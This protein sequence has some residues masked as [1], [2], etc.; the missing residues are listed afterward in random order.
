MYKPETGGQG[1]DNQTKAAHGCDCGVEKPD[2]IHGKIRTGVY[3][4]HC[5]TNI[6]AVVDVKSVAAYGGTLGPKSRA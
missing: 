6:A 2:A 5:G 3:V 1:P 4:C